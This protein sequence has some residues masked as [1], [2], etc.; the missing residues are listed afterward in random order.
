[1][2][3]PQEMPSFQEDNE[4]APQGGPVGKKLRP[5]LKLVG[6]QR[7]ETANEAL[8]LIDVNQSIDALTGN[9]AKIEEEITDVLAELPDINTKDAMENRLRLL[10]E[11][12]EDEKRELAKWQEKKKKIDGMIEAEAAKKK[13]EAE[14][15]ARGMAE[16]MK[17]ETERLYSQ[18]ESIP[19]DQ[20]AGTW[21]KQDEQPVAPVEVPKRSWIPASVRKWGRRLLLGLGLLG[22]G[23]AAEPTLS[24]LNQSVNETFEQYQAGVE[25][26]AETMADPIGAQERWDQARAAER[27]TASPES[28]TKRIVGE[29]MVITGDVPARVQE[30]EQQS[31]HIESIKGLP[32]NY[33]G[34]DFLNDQE[35]FQHFKNYGAGEHVTSKVALEAFGRMIQFNKEKAKE[36]AE[37]KV[38]DKKVVDKL[39]KNFDEVLK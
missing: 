34:T 15:V 18:P 16:Q 23:K 1:M 38:T 8:K 22:A 32:N 28:S 7:S 20:L 19:E 5:K 2:S 12:L 33:N 27:A 9:I 36:A 21:V 31:R 37:Q 39:M 29:E 10:N 6:G 13:A 4:I 24:D 25:S 17:K 35:T 11:D 14:A 30:M 3:K 26:F